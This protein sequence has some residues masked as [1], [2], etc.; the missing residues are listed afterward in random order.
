MMINHVTSEPGLRQNMSNNSQLEAESW[1]LYLL[2]DEFLIE[3]I[4]RFA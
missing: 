4:K 3:K 2:V 1:F